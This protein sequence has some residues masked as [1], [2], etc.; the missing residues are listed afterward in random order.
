MYE[1]YY[2]RFFRTVNI[3]GGIRVMVNVCVKLLKN[4]NCKSSLLLTER[5]NTEAISYKKS[6]ESSKTEEYDTI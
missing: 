4:E 2:I 6:Y 1:I 5:Y 3:I